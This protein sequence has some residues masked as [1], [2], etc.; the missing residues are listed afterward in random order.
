MRPN[1]LTWI[2]NTAMRRLIRVIEFF[3]NRLTAE[4]VGQIAD[5]VGEH[6]AGSAL[7]DGVVVECLRIIVDRHGRRAQ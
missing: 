4:Q 6:G 2:E 3:V 1:A 7:V 5:H